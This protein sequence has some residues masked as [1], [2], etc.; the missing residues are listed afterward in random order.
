MEKEIYIIRNKINNKV[1]IGQSVNSS[2]R[3]KHHIYDG[4]NNK[5]NS[6]IDQ[7]IKEFGANNFW[8]EILESTTDYDSREKYWI[9]YYNSLTPDGYNIMAGGAGG[10]SGTE[11]IKSL[12]REEGLLQQ[13]IDDIQ[14]SELKLVEIGNKYN[15]SLKLISSINRGTAYHDK[16]LSYPLRKRFSD[17][18][19]DNIN[20]L[21][22]EELLNT[23]KSYREL[24]QKYSVT[25]FYIGEINKGI[26]QNSLINDFPIRKKEIDPIFEQIKFELINTNKSLRKIAEDLGVSY[27]KVQTF[28]SGRY[29]YD[30]NLTYPIRQP[31]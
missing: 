19:I 25:T 30:P 23:S 21:I 4:L 27:S 24:A 28:N 31:K 3:F 11:S 29:H 15:L 12:I 5:G 18:L 7:A 2:I 17:K 6:L 1:Y 10:G 26:R 14:N 22:A 8:Y 13:I 9:K 16:N 20:D